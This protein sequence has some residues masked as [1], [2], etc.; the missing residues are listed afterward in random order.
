[1]KLRLQH[2]ALSFLKEQQFLTN[3]LV[4]TRSELDICS[5]WFMLVSLVFP[6]TAS[7]YTL[8]SIDAGSLMS[9]YTKLPPVLQF[10]G[11]YP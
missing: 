7:L 3:E 4:F 9:N 5:G 1:M 6:Y 11:N 8:Q 10:V 2:D